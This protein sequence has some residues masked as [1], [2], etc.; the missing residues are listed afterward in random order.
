MYGRPPSSCREIVCY[1]A[2]EE[3]DFMYSNLI[4]KFTC[5]MI[6]ASSFDCEF[7][8]LTQTDDRPRDDIS[9]ARSPVKIESN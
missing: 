5:T 8:K 4:P 2:S 6:M 7:V 9:L 3:K 1:S